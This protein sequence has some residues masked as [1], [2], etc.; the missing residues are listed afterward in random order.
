MVTNA[1]KFNNKRK[2]RKREALV[3]SAETLR[4]KMMRPQRDYGDPD[5]Y[6][7]SQKKTSKPTSAYEVY[8]A[9][10]T[11]PYYSAIHV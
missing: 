6:N 4:L 8:D 7:E 11:P 1:I 9:I 3:P 5:E 10:C 2:R